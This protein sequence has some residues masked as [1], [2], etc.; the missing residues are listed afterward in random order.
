MNALI[1]KSQ[2]WTGWVISGLVILAMLLA[3]AMKF[4]PMDENGKKELAKIGWEQDKLPKLAVTEIACAILYAI[5]QTSILGAVLLTGY[6]GGTIAT[7]ARIGDLFVA[8]AV[9]GVLVWAGLWLREPR[10][11][12][13]LPFRSS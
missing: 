8:Q 9:I 10:L 12:A 6:L 7:H 11:R 3:G 4:A 13:L 1:S 5:P 2:F